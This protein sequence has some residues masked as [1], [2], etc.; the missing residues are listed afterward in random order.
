MSRERILN[1]K[2][3]ELFYSLIIIKHKMFENVKNENTRERYITAIDF[4]RRT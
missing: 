4:L 2:F 1:F 3:I